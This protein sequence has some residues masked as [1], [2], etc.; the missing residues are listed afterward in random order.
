M[1]QPQPLKLVPQGPVP[2]PLLHCPERGHLQ[3]R[4]R[5]VL[6]EEP[7][8]HLVHLPLE[9]HTPLHPVPAVSLSQGPLLLPRL[10]EP[11]RGPQPAE[12]L[13][14][15]LARRGDLHLVRVRLPLLYVLELSKLLVELGDE[16]LLLRNVRPHLEQA[17][18]H[19]LRLLELARPVPHVRLHLLLHHLV[20][21][22]QP[23]PPLNLQRGSLLHAGRQRLPEDVALPR[24]LPRHDAVLLPQALD[25]RLHPLHLLRARVPQPPQLVDVIVHIEGAH[26][27]HVGLE[28]RQRALQRLLH[29]HRPRHP[30]E[31]RGPHRSP[32][33]PGQV[34]DPPLCR[35]QDAARLRRLRSDGQEGEGP[36]PAVL[37]PLQ[38]HLPRLCQLAGALLLRLGQPVLLELGALRGIIEK[39][40]HYAVAP[41]LL[42]LRLLSQHLCRLCV[43]GSLHLPRSLLSPK[44]HPHTQHEELNHTLEHSPQSV[45]RAVSS[46]GTTDWPALVPVLCLS[47]RKPLCSVFQVV[48][49]VEIRTGASLPQR[50]H[51]P[52]QHIH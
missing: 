11:P 44:P 4:Q 30:L 7:L 15:E 36:L 2:G 6:G 37:V 45:D 3:P 5:L 49:Q 25:V 42:L 14:D 40:F 32:R 16:L 34:D 20:L 41:L 24:E 23:L 48:L 39:D 10:L 28:R 26:S 51:L 8:L 43:P 13:G 52:P 21:A 18:P 50:R 33:L 22:F 29:Q 1:V 35:C 27:L 31:P 19:P 46:S 47:F 38:P 17:L 9:R 12:L